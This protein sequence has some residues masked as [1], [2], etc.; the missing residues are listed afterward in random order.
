MEI[1]NN[2]GIA[3]QTAA[4]A[5]YPE[6]FVIAC[7][8]YRL[9]PEELLQQFVNRFYYSG[10]MCGAE[11]DTEH[12]V[13]EAIFD[14]LNPLS[15]GIGIAPAN[16]VLHRKWLKKLNAIIN[17]DWKL[18]D[19]E[20][21]ANMTYTLKSCRKEVC[22]SLPVA[23]E[24]SIPGN[25][26]I[27]LTSNFIV[28]CFMYGVSPEYVL[29]HLVDHISLAKEAAV[30]QFGVAVFNPFMNFFHSIAKQF[31]KDSKELHA[32]GFYQYDKE[33]VALYHQLQKETNYDKRLSALTK[34]YKVWY[35]AIKD[36][37]V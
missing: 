9:R 18:P 13:N 31:F 16:R 26:I 15:K 10:L 8:I 11:D 5:E 28:M 22:K 24:I 4:I 2:L 30:N 14:Y 36:L 6:E 29:R 27:Q 3:D 12:A 1:K 23:T 32:A 25:C 37:P 35:T 34:H 21:R 20:L 17:R 33:L 19:Q 7:G